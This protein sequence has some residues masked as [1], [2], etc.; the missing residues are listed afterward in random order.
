M[1]FLS[2]S[3]ALGEIGACPWLPSW[4][5][6][7]FTSSSFSLSVYT[8]V[9]VLCNVYIRAPLSCASACPRAH[10]GLLSPWFELLGA[11]SVLHGIGT[12]W[13]LLLALLRLVWGCPNECNGSS[14]SFVKRNVNYFQQSNYEA[15]ERL[16]EITFPLITLAQVLFEAIFWARCNA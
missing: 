12:W 14:V 6:H 11:D 9:I 15:N 5:S 3:R 1:P 8:C 13:V 7:A 2:F 16:T 4:Y 10:P